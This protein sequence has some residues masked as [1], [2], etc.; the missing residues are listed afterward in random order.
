MIFWGNYDN[1]YPPLSFLQMLIMY[2]IVSYATEHFL[3]VSRCQLICS[4]IFE[5][6]HS[7]FNSEK[8]IEYFE[9]TH[10]DMFKSQKVLE[11]LNLE[12]KKAAVAYFRFPKK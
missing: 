11:I 6:K 4:N 7:E 1:G 8:G 12:I 9:C 10:Y 5:T 3:R 2:P